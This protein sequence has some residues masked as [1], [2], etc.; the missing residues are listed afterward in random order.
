MTQIISI[1]TYL[2]CYIQIIIFFF[3][4]LT[5]FIKNLENNYSF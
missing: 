2:K 3:K 5:E 4:K 1:K